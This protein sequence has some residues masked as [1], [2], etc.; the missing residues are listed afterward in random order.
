MDLLSASTTGPWA[1][2]NKSYMLLLWPLSFCG[3]LFPVWKTILTIGQRQLWLV[4]DGLLGL[5]L[6]HLFPRCRNHRSAG[7]V[8]SRRHLFHTMVCF[9][10]RVERADAA[11]RSLQGPWGRC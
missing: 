8:V 6:D 1:V 10:L 3:Y 4:R 2:V 7:N 5:T 11:P 9:S